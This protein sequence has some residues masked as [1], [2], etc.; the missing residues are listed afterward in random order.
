MGGAAFA[1]SSAQIAFGTDRPRASDEDVKV[2]IDRILLNGWRNGDVSSA[3]MAF[4]A[5]L[6][7]ARTGIS[8]ADAEKRVSEVIAQAK[9]TMV[10]A[11]A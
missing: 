1:A 10:G 2:E 6:V 11:S 9:E 4:L 3:D 7:A 8:E 5:Q